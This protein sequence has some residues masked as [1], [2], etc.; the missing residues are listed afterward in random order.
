[1]DFAIARNIRLPGGRQIQLRGE[2]YNAF[3]TVIFT[4]RNTT[5]NFPNLTS[6]TANLASNLVYDATTGALLSGRDIP[7][8]A[9]FGAVNNS[10]NGRSVQLQ[11]RFAF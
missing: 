2:M 11:I 1:M 5:V 8:T 3:N 6:N 10:N 9:G 4:G 7:R